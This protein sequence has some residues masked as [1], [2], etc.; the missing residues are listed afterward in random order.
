VIHKKLLNRHSAAKLAAFRVGG[1]SRTDHHAKRS[2][3]GGLVYRGELG[4]GNG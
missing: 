2:C 3:G 4:K 1:E